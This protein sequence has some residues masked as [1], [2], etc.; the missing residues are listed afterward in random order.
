MRRTCVLG[1]G[2]LLAG[3]ASAGGF[4]ETRDPSRAISAAQEQIALAEEAGA[5]SLAP[6][7]L[8]SAR[9]NLQ[10]A[11]A[12]RRGRERVTDENARRAAVIAEEAEAD[13]IYAKAQADRVRTERE[14][15]Q[16]Q[17]ALAALPPRGGAQ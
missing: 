16:A 10:A 3:C 17:A 5:D 7:A 15:S 8:G 14:R 11:V 6:D 9:R 12:L 1:L 4:P 2:A 13:A